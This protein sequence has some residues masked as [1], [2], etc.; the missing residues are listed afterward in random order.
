MFLIPVFLLCLYDQDDQGPGNGAE[1]KRKE[2]EHNAVFGREVCVIVIICDECLIILKYIF[3]IVYINV[4]SIGAIF[5]QFVF[6][7]FSK[8]KGREMELNTKGKKKSS[9]PFVAGRY[10]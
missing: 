7:I 4:S 5:T 9:T 1:D 3:L 10:L 6:F 8:R 2:K